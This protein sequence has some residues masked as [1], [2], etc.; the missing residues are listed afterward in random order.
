[1]LYYFTS[2]LSYFIASVDKLSNIVW[3][4][5]SNMLSKVWLHCLANPSLPMCKLI[6]YFIFCKV[7]SVPVMLLLIIILSGI[8]WPYG[9]CRLKSFFLSWRLSLSENYWML[10][11]TISLFIGQKKKTPLITPSPSDPL[12]ELFSLEDLEKTSLFPQALLLTPR[13]SIKLPIEK[14][15]LEH[16]VHIFISVQYFD[17]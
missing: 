12:L 7:F 10:V 14:T 6:T 4:W 1:M 9:H 16:H 5:P 15:N 17:I 8:M 2:V 11:H 3:R 13:N